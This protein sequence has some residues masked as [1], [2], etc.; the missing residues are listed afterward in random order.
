MWSKRSDKYALGI[1]LDYRTSGRHAISCRTSWSSDDNAVPNKSCHHVAIKEDF[2]LNCIRRRASVYDH[3]VGNVEVSHTHWLR[4]G[5]VVAS[6]HL[7][8]RIWLH[9]HFQS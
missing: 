9:T 7:S 1:R 3:L 4:L 2:Q 6:K 8:H 5:Q